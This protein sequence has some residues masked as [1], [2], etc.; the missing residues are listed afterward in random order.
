MLKKTRKVSL[1]DCPLTLQTIIYFLLLSLHRYTILKNKLIDKG[2][3]PTEILVINIYQDSTSELQL[4]VSQINWNVP[5]VIV[6]PL[7]HTT[8][9]MKMLTRKKIKSTLTSTFIARNA[10]SALFHLKNKTR[11]KVTKTLR[12][13]VLSIQ[14][15]NGIKTIQIK[16]SLNVEITLN[17]N[18]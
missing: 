13:T 16:R 5:L 10:I 12:D 3:S 15:R 11:V 1:F 6:S 2:S 7:S 18:C 4:M 9:M 17:A 8:V 14:G